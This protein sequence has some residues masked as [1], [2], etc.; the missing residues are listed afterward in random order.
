MK[1]KSSYALLRL[2]TEWWEILD[3][4][5]TNRHTHQRTEARTIGQTDQRTDQRTDQWTDR[6]WDIKIERIDWKLKERDW[7][8]VWDTHL[9]I[10]S[11]LAHSQRSEI[12]EPPSQPAK[13]S[14]SQQKPAKVSKIQ[15]KSAKAECQKPIIKRR[16][17]ICL[18]WRL[19][20]ETNKDGPVE[21]AISRFLLGAFLPSFF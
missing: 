3:Q 20:G 15:Q 6:R 21:E 9:S 18:P 4:D 7:D 1:D 17:L 10:L 19:D 14:K 16:F 5:P 13:A 2:A 8:G 11:S 12:A